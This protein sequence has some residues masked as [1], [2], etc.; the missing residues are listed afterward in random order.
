MGFDLRH[1]STFETPCDTPPLQRLRRSIERDHD[2]QR[3]RP[4]LMK[5]RNVAR[6]SDAGLLPHHAQPFL[7]S[8]YPKPIRRPRTL[9][10]IIFETRR[11]PCRIAVCADGEN[12]SLKDCFQVSINKS[13]KQFR[14]TISLH[15]LHELRFAENRKPNTENLK[16]PRSGLELF[17]RQCSA[18]CNRRAS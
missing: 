14:L 2:R 6:V 4:R 18:P 15:A 7:D 5:R 1:G 8:G 16:P 12:K 13:R 3:Q 10:T 9:I 17:P 11:R